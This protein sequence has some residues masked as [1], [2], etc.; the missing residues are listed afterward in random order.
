LVGA[1]DGRGL[2]VSS[3]DSQMQPYL[4]A[5]VEASGAAPDL[6]FP[7]R[8]FLHLHALRLVNRWQWHFMGTQMRAHAGKRHVTIWRDELDNLIA[9]GLI[10]ASHGVSYRVTDAGRET[11]CAANKT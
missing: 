10:E 11:I 5:V 4:A 3:V 7:Q 1:R 6:T 8:N 2:A 9:R